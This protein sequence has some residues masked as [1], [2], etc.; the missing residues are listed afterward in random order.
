MTSFNSQQYLDSFTNFEINLHKLSG[1]EFDLGRVVGLLDFLGRPD[2]K[3]KI[4]H[5][6][7]TKGKGSTCAF[8]SHVLAASGFR[9]GL[10]TSPHLHHVHERI[11]VLDKAVID[12]GEDFAGT[13]T[14]EQLAQTVNAL[15]PHIAAMTNRGSF[16]TY[17]EVL[18]VAALYFFSRQNL[19][20]VVLETGL[21]GRLDA[22]N[23]VDS[24]VAVITPISLDHTRILGKTLEAI[25]VEKTGIIKSS[26]QRVVA[27]PQD[28]KVMAV[29]LNR[30]RE[31]GIPP[32][33]A[34]PA[35]YRDM[36]IPLKGEHQKV[37]AATALH[38]VELL[39]VWGHK[40]SDAAIAQGLKR[41]R[42]PGRF[43]LLRKKP[44]VIVDSA[45][46]RASARAL[47]KT[48]MGEYPGRA[49]T[50]VLGTS[51]DK[52][53]EGLAGEL[54][55]V[56][57]TVIL[58]KA[59]HP[60]AYDFRPAHAGQLFPGRECFVTGNV[61]DALEMALSKAK[62]DDVIVAAGSIF[63]AAEVRDKINHVSV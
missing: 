58:T 31:F 24:L 1:Q 46:N 57:S 52:D 17:F 19:D 22:T 8:L 39:R 34:D 45:H 21:G 59:D 32:I 53:I 23:A 30:C 28:E 37:N 16:L 29:I 56:V 50:L 7:G 4:I 35:K 47:A 44:A 62:K 38:V 10:F 33:I 14:G 25:A 26:Q 43:E 12:R 11:R 41:T 13:I 36:A 20:W 5:V 2:K 6:A 60:R 27:A 9:V 49:V 3:L 55:D 51:S 54:K 15:R 61:D 48:I 40:I 63:I 42:W 18:T